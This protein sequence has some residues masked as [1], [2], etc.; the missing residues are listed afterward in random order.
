MLCLIREQVKMRV[1]GRSVIVLLSFILLFG[2]AQCSEKKPEKVLS[3]AE[4]VAILTDIY[5]AEEKV[6]RLAIRYDSMKVVFPYFEERIYAKYGVS[7]SLLTHSFQYY[8][9]HPDK[10]DGIYTA[11]IDSLNLK[12]QGIREDLDNP[13]ALSQ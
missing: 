13:D 2:L 12:E 6:S 10:L 11:V 5:L 1:K 7:D 3:E 8:L 4:M 9:Q